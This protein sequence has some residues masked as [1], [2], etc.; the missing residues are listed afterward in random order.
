[1][2]CGAST[3]QDQ[4]KGEKRKKAKKGGDGAKYE[5]NGKPPSA[6]DGEGGS[7][8]REGSVSDDDLSYVGSEYEKQLAA[9]SGMPLSEKDRLKAAWIG[10]W[11]DQ[12][13]ASNFA[14]A[15]LE[16]A[17]LLSKYSTMVGTAAPASQQQKSAQAGDGE[18]QP[19]VH[20][21]PEFMLERPADEANGAGGNGDGLPRRQSAGAISRVSNYNTPGVMNSSTN[22]PVTFNASLASNDTVQTAA[23]GGQEGDADGGPSGATR[24]RTPSADTIAANQPGGLGSQ[25]GS[26]LSQF[27]QQLGAVNSGEFLSASDSAPFH[28]EPHAHLSAEGGSLANSARRHNSG[29]DGFP[30]YHPSRGDSQGAATATASGTVTGVE[31]SNNGSPVN[32]ELSLDHSTTPGSP[33]SNM[34]RMQES[35]EE[36]PLIPNQPREAGRHPIHEANVFLGGVMKVISV[37]PEH[38]RNGLA[39]HDGGNAMN[40]HTTEVESSGIGSSAVASRSPAGSPMPQGVT[41]HSAVRVGSGIAPLSPANTSVI[42]IKSPSGNSVQIFHQPQ[43]DNGPGVE[44]FDDL[45]YELLVALAKNHPLPHQV[46]VALCA[47]SATAHVAKRNHTYL[48]F[49]PIGTTTNNLMRWEQE[50]DRS[51]LLIVA[52]NR[53]VPTGLL[54]L[55]A[56]EVQYSGVE[57]FEIFKSVAEVAGA[58]P[59]GPMYQSP[60]P[61]GFRA[62]VSEWTTF[63]LKFAVTLTFGTAGSQ[64]VSKEGSG[65]FSQSTQPGGESTGIGAS[66]HPPVSPQS[67]VGKKS[68]DSPMPSF[69]KKL[70][71]PSEAANVAR[72]LVAV[73]HRMSSP[74]ASLSSF[75]KIH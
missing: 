3:E 30:A 32:S 29:T 74:V 22:N 43:R 72:S 70:P 8:K 68:T 53:G 40:L 19:G 58:E 50:V 24:V 41:P 65:Q 63:I 67:L 10:R 18:K 55:T 21:L 14:T 75:R 16:E 15:L 54:S 38:L 51:V 4:G 62:A 60:S 12:V 26:Q 27:P 37:L 33:S 25:R 35:W 59:T 64:Q 36:E 46:S 11:V 6:S 9:T 13:F 56:A 45:D 28:P 73:H 61:L 34:K 2:G 52:Q 71:S 17:S 48:H 1:M 57:D 31:L 20:E 49:E 5:G 47:P 44:K 42:T 66:H 39:S 7:N 23:H 69:F